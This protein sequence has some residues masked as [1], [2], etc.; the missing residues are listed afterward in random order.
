MGGTPLAGNATRGTLGLPLRKGRLHLVPPAQLA[1]TA[2]LQDFQVAPRAP[3]ESQTMERTLLAGNVALAI[4][5]TLLRKGCLHLVPPAQLANTARLQDRQSAL[6]AA[7]VTMAPPQE[8]LEVIAT[9]LAPRAS[10]LLRAPPP[11]RSAQRATLGPQRATRQAPATA[12]ASREHLVAL[13]QLPAQIAQRGLFLVPPPPPA[14]H[15]PLARSAPSP[16]PHLRRLAFPAPLALTPC[17]VA[18]RPASPAPQAMLAPT[19]PL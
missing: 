9:A 6:S 16:P 19:H 15:A 2:R 17:T 18:P 11:A 1:N 7:R 8:V 5:G 14:R 3:L 10:I 4:L 13:A 12:P